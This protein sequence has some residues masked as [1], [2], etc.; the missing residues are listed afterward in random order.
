MI[1]AFRPS[2][3]ENA[4]F[5]N[6]GKGRAA[7]IFGNA[8][9]INTVKSDNLPINDVFICNHF[10]SHIHYKK[11]KSGFHC[12]SDRYFLDHPRIQEF[13]DN[14]NNNIKLITTRK[15]WK[16]LND[17][18][19]Q[20][21]VILVN[22]SGSK[23]IYDEYNSL[24]YDLTKI[25]Q[26]GATVAAEFCFPAAYYMGFKEIKILGFDMDYGE[27]LDNYGV[28]VRGALF[29]NRTY[30]K[31]IWPRLAIT[32][33]QRWINYCSERDIQVRSLTHTKLDV[34]YSSPH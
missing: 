12:V 24:T 5:I 33:M 31:N 32:S 16:G 2:Y 23:P 28:D 21:D 14:N 27:N 26:T 3:C 34:M 17:K 7:T 22:Y 10:W 30:L 29:T 1:D 25:L 20:G 4:Q 19:F 8:S 15:I 13:I 6:Y 18:G 11:I 9:S